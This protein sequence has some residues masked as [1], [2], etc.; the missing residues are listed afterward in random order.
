MTTANRQKIVA[1]NW[2]ENGSLALVESITKGLNNISL[3]TVEVIVCPPFPYLISAS[4]SEAI[5]IG[6]QDIALHAE[7]AHTGDVSGTM[8]AEVGCKYVI[9]GH[10][11][12]RQDHAESNEAVAIKAQNALDAGLTPI[13]CFGEPESVREDG[14]LNDYLKAQLEPVIAKL[15]I[16]NLSNVVLAYEPTWAIG[17]GKTASP[18]QAQEVHKFV[19][20]F[21]AAQNADVAEAVSILYGGSVKPANAQELFS[22]N[23]IDGGLI[24]GASLDLDS[25]VAICQAAE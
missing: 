8:L 2:K 12:R 5:A 17:T 24:G 6:A 16:T 11:E 13:I 25:F 21:I 7:G 15:G 23:D 1:G 3:D 9:V 18:E 4:K 19:R 14:S 22:Q 10:S 20:E